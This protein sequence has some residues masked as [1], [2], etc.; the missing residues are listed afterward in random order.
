MLRILLIDKDDSRRVTRVMLLEH[1]GYEVVTANRFQDV[2]GTVAESGF[3]LVILET[4]DIEK[5]AVAYGERLK[6]I[7]PKLPILVLSSNGLFLPKESLLTSFHGVHPTPP[8]VMARIAALLMRS[9]H[10]RQE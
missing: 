9:T 4:D 6:A 1:E 2:E 8:E 5:A 10:K 7:R 3:D